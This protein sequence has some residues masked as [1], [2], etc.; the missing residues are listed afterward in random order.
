MDNIFNIPPLENGDRLTRVEFERRYYAMPS[1]QKAELVEG[2]VYMDFPVRF[3][4][5]AK[6]HALIISWLGIY[7]AATPEVD[8]G[9]NATVRL[10]INNEYQPDALLRLTEKVGG[11]SSISQD[12][13]IEGAPELIVEVAASSAANDLHDKKEVYRRNGVQEY[14]VWQVYE[15]R[16]DWFR[17]QDGDYVTLKPDSNGLIQSQIFPGLILAVPALLENNLT[18]VLAEL[19]KNLHTQKQHSA[20]V[21]QLLASINK[22]A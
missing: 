12:D 2:T 6:P 3:R 8:L 17:L 16:L 19:Q 11:Q 18:T 15:Q 7:C 14:L 1:I 9:D 4:S 22:S 20:F 10:D 13:Y 21:E 5:H